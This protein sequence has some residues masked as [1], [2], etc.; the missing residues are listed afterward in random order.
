M[1]PAR[2]YPETIKMSIFDSIMTLIF[3]GKWMRSYTLYSA[4][5]PGQE[6]YDEAPYEQTVE[7]IPGVWKTEVK[8]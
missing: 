7:Y 6:G 4:V 8:R 1:K 2:F 3:D 5:M